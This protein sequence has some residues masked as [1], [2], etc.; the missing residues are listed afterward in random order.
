M[1]SWGSSL[2]SFNSIHWSH[3]AQAL[4]HALSHHHQDCLSPASVHSLPASTCLFTCFPKKHSSN[5][6]NW[7]RCPSSVLSIYKDIWRAAEKERG[8]VF[9]PI[10]TSRSRIKSYLGIVYG[11][12]PE[13]YEKI[14]KCLWNKWVNEWMKLPNQHVNPQ[15]QWFLLFCSALSLASETILGTLNICQNN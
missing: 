9:L 11:L 10:V 15:T 3:L 2:H 8:H 12:R 13:S 6:S 14:S 5:H 7:T 1:F 4:G